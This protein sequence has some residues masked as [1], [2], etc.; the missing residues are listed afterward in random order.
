MNVEQE[1]SR[2]LWMDL[3]TIDLGTLPGDLQTDVLVVGAGIAGTVLALE[4][5]HHGVGCVV[6]ERSTEAS[7]SSRVHVVNGRS[8]ELLRRLGLSPVIRGGAVECDDS[9]KLL[10]TDALDQPPILVWHQ[11]SADQLRQRY[12]SVNDGT[13]PAESH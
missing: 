3:P 5:A 2:S 8:M 12:A 13:A 6:V 9:T 11:P 4:L 7:S 10:F 1:S